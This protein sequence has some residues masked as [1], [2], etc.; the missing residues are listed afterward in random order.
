MAPSYQQLE[1]R[2]LKLQDECESLTLKNKEY[3]DRIADQEHTID[4]QFQELDRLRD[5]CK[6]LKQ[7]S[8]NEL[9]KT[10]S[11]QQAEIFQLKETAKAFAEEEQKLKREISERDNYIERMNSTQKTNKEQY[12][13]SIQRLEDENKHYKEKLRSCQSE[14]DKLS[15]KLAEKGDL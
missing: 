1:D 14:I 11:E 4:E 3:K 2:I 13:E 10:T 12:E 8:S 9:E 5:T 7:G 15:A 6:E